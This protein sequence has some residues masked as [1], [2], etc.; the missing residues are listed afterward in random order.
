MSPNTPDGAETVAEVGEFGL[1]ERITRGRQQPRSTLLGPGDDAAVVAAPDGRVVACTDVLVEGVHFRLDWSNPDH[2]GRKAVA[3]NLADIAAMGAV[4]TAVLVGLAC[5]SGTS[6]AVVDQLTAGMW[7]EAARARVGVVGGDL[8]EAPT[9]VISITALG[10]LRG[11]KPVTRGGAMP[12]DVV[13]VA[14]RLGWSAAGLAVLGRGFRSPVSVVGAHRAPEPPYPAGPQAA[15]AGATAMID[16]SDGLLADLGHIGTASNVAIDI[17]GDLIE[18]HQ[19]LVDVAAALGGDPRHW[20]LTGGED[21]ALAATFPDPAGVPDGWRTIGTV[22]RGN[23]VTV[24]G[25]P[26]TGAAGWQHWR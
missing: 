15:D 12:G 26:Y 11:R 8:T 23:G 5:P 7:H 2:V 6:A 3:V 13:A 14:G 18:V 10:D 17:R 4:P 9:L 16:V 1:I 19:R 21:H 22:T 20:V 25:V 24:D